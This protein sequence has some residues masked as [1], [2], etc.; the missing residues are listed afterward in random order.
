MEPERRGGERRPLGAAYT[1]PA[2]VT[3]HCRGLLGELPTLIIDPWEMPRRA[4][5]SEKAGRRLDQSPAQ[6]D[7][8]GD[9][10]EHGEGSA[11]PH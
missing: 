2:E 11:F 9:S 5:G 4:S 7:S 6:E 10:P 8:L 1:L 3:P